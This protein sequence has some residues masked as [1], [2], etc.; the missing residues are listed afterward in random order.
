MIDNLLFQWNKVKDHKP[1]PRMEE[2]KNRLPAQYSCLTLH[3]PSNVDSKESLQ[4]IFKALK[5]ISNKVPILFPCHPR[6]LKNIKKFGLTSQLSKLDTKSTPL[7]KGIY[8]LE[9]L[10]YNEFLYFWKDSALM[11]TDSGGLQEETTALKIPCVTIRE[12]TERPIT[13]TEG[14]NI[15]VGQDMQRL[16]AEARRDRSGVLRHG[17]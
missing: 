6:T 1:V 15:L 16:H 5:T 9:P 7:K 2:I 13:I 4:E 12:N 3:R 17:V 14:T 8:L 10:G 11:L